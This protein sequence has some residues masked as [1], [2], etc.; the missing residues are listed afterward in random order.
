[1][2]KQSLISRLRDELEF[3]SGGKLQVNLPVKNELKHLA[4]NTIH[5]YLQLPLGVQ[6][7]VQWSYSLQG[8]YGAKVGQKGGYVFQMSHGTQQI[9]EYNPESYKTN[10]ENTPLRKRARLIM[11]EAM[12]HPQEGRK[13]LIRELYRK[14]PYRLK[15]DEPVNLR[16]KNFYFDRETI[17]DDEL[18]MYHAADPNNPN[19]E[20]DT[21]ITEKKYGPKREIKFEYEGRV[22]EH[23]YAVNRRTRE[24]SNTLHFIWEV[25]F[26]PVIKRREKQ[27]EAQDYEVGMEEKHGEVQSCEVVRFRDG[28]LPIPLKN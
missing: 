6:L 13:E 12:Q 28:I 18:I 20:T 23:Y 8:K 25:E 19:P 21:V 11:Q 4:T 14:T 24:L 17:K 5:N 3:R 26:D 22:E 16:M 1:M 10:S 2:S 27:E 15:Q 7:A 9:K